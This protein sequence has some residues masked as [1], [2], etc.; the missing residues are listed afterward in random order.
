MMI[1]AHH[2][3]LHGRFNYDDA[4]TL[5]SLWITFFGM[6]GKLGVDIFA[7]I[8]GYFAVR[9]LRLRP[10]RLIRLWLMAIFYSLG[11]Y[12]L[13][14]ALGVY[15]FKLYDFLPNLFPISSD[16]WWFLTCYFV[17]MLLSPLLNRLLCSLSQSTYRK[18]LA[19]MIIMWSVI[20]TLTGFKLYSN[21]F[22]CIVCMY[23]VGGYIRLWRDDK[24][25]RPVPCILLAAALMLAVFGLI[26]M[27]Q[28]V[29]FGDYKGYIPTYQHNWSILVVIAA[30]LLFLGFKNINMGS[31]RFIN[32]VSAATLG[33]YMIHD[34]PYIRWYIVWTRLFRNTSHAQSSDLIPFSIGVVA[35]VFAGCAV[36]ELLRIHLIERWYMKPI[37]KN[38][39]KISGFIDRVCQKVLRF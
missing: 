39:E 33:V 17:L 16:R 2:F 38:E 12:L 34:N 15:P 21:D 10:A 13:L 19:I 27:S 8:S 25:N 18:L 20:Y 31:I 11:I 5:N 35:A 9:S 3:C 24:K 37:M 1:I 23:C 7:V 36:I 14:A 32:A 28:Q 6:S 4:V 30:I 29:D 26:V 22:I